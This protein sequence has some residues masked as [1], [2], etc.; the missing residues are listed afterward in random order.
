MFIDSPELYDAI[1][2]FKNYSRECDRL[3]GL[4][5]QF[6]PGARSLLDVACGTGGHAKFLKQ[7]YEVDGVDINKNYIGAARQKNPMGRYST[8]DMIDFDLDRTYDVVTCLFS[9]IAIVRT[10]GRLER[11][12]ACMARHVRAGGLLLIEPWFTPQQWRPPKPS[13][14]AGEI[15]A[16]K[17]YRLSR[18]VKKGQLS[19]LLHSYLKMTPDGVEYSSESIE[20]GL[21]TR[22][23][24]TWAFEFAGMDVQYD[25]EG[26]MGRGL[27]IGKHT[28]MH[29]EL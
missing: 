25:P 1:Y 2:H 22:D 12:V 3:R 4:I 27:Y 9:A 19:V 11:A 28:E 23:E 18:S 5:S 20:L 24:M 13:I 6:V 14:L 26:L 7:Y 8:A 21:F 16:D 15:G 17:V 10:F 29:S